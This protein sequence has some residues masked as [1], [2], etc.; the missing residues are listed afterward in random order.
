MFMSMCA[1]KREVFISIPLKEISIELD[2]LSLSHFKYSQ[3]RLIYF[4]GCT[5]SV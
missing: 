5:L 4:L 1:K 2:T 3:I